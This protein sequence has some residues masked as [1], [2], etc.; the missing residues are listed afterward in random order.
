MIRSATLGLLLLIATATVS[1]AQS[2]A[3][4][5][6]K[7]ALLA[8][9]AAAHAGDLKADAAFYYATDD[10]QRKLIPL[11]AK[12]DVALA[13]LQDAVSSKFGAELGVA[14]VRAAGT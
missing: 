11:I 5:S 10:H 2:D 6:P 4:K 3:G 12:G 14:V 9:D 1:R 13:K 7:D 8:Q